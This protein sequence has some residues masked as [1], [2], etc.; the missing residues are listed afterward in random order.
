M[1]S[2]DKAPFILNLEIVGTGRRCGDPNIYRS[3]G[4][5]VPSLPPL[6]VLQIALPPDIPA[7]AYSEEEQEVEDDPDTL[8]PSAAG[9]GAQ[10]SPSPAPQQSS[11]RIVDNES[12][13]EDS[14]SETTSEAA[15]VKSSEPVDIQ[16]EADEADS[17]KHTAQSFS[18]LREPTHV[19]PKSASSAPSTPTNSQTAHPQRWATL[20]T[21]RPD[22]PDSPVNRDYTLNKG[23]KLAQ[24]EIAQV[25]GHPW[26]AT[27]HNFA[28]LSPDSHLPNWDMLSVIYKAGDDCRQEALAMQLI[29]VF[30]HA[31]NRAQLPLR[32]RPYYTLVTSHCSGV[33]ETVPDTMSVDGIKRKLGGKMRLNQFIHKVFGRSEA[34]LTRAKR[35]FTESMA[36]YSIVT[37]LLQIKDRHNGNILMDSEAN[38]IHVDFG[39]ML[40]NTPGNV[41]FETAP[42]KLSREYIEV[43]GGESS[44]LFSYFKL[45]VVKGFLEIR[46]YAQQLILLVEIMSHGSQMPCFQ[47]TP[48]EVVVKNFRD[49]F[50]LHLP[51][52]GCMRHVMSLIDLSCNNWRTTQYDN[53]QRLT[54]GIL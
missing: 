14:A 3:Y 39:F 20:P 7:E 9:N 54:N 31:F 49:R 50:V 46:K 40:S 34:M 25:F 51:Q 16:V 12:E 35:N 38:L 30:H 29:N 41:S 33:I 42:F 21:S 47:G 44:A 17:P 22:L 52:A 8:P 43:M 48:A 5:Q 32:L 10:E 36:G 23:D 45:L 1:S 27:V 18:L 11:S 15:E 6:P 2:R 37:Y 28:L 26:H 24:Q 13:Q 4:S 53:Y 19:S